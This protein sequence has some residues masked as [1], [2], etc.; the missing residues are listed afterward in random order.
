[1]K[2]LDI[3]WENW[4]NIWFAPAGFR[5][6]CGK[7][8][9]HHSILMEHDYIFLAVKGREPSHES[10]AQGRFHSTGTSPFGNRR[11]QLLCWN[12][13]FLV[14]L[15]FEKLCDSEVNGLFWDVLWNFVD[16]TNTV[17]VI[18]L[19]EQRGSFKVF[20]RWHPSKLSGVNVLWSGFK[21][22]S[23]FEVLFKL[24]LCQNPMGTLWTVRGNLDLVDA[25]EW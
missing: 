2:C 9:I 13:I 23:P 25:P 7:S 11:K 24:W 1:M 5:L 10:T 15:F 12:F 4:Q 22:F 6:P 17:P 18:V 19:F 21:D 8:C 16:F 20:V 14:Q 3:F